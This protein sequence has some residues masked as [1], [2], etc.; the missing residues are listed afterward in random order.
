MELAIIL[1]AGAVVLIVWLYLWS[2]Q[3][4]KLGRIP[5]VEELLA[6]V[7]TAAG[8]AVLV[9]REH[10]EPPVTGALLGAAVAVAAAHL[11]FQVRGRM[12]M[13]GVLSGIIE[14][15]AVVSICACCVP[16]VHADGV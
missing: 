3:K 14:D 15:A 4:E 13:N 10:G 6:N 11:A 1:F 8:D 2:L 9:A 16:R 12:P 7:Q 5:E